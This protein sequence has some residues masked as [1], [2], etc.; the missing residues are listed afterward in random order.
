MNEIKR[1][2]LELEKQKK[3]LKGEISK[4]KSFSKKL[5]TGGKI[6]GFIPKLEEFGVA[7]KLGKVF[8]N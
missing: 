1:H 6:L 7:K 2:I 4:V 8:A 3:E 5:N